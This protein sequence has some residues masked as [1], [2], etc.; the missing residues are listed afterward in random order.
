MNLK[1]I[2]T[3]IFFGAC[4]YSSAQQ[5]S[6]FANS[7]YNPY[8]LNP[9]A[10]GLMNVMQI[11]STTRFQ[12]SGY[13]GSPRTIM[14][15]G[16]APIS[17]GGSQGTDEYNAYKENF[18]GS[19]TM[20][21]GSKK[22][23]VGGKFI[24]DAIGPFMRTSLYGSYA[25]HLPFSKSINFGAG[26]GLGFSNFSINQD[27][28]TLYH[29]DD[30]TYGD[31][32]SNSANQNYL[33]ANAGIVFYSEKFMAGISMQQ[34]F[35][36]KAQF[37]DVLTQSRFNRHFFLTARYRFD[38]DFEMGIEPLT[39]IKYEIGSPISVDLGARFVYQNKFWGGLQYRT[40]NAI[41]LQAGG[42]LIKNTYLNYSFEIATGAIS[43]YSNGSHEIQLGIYIGN[44]RN[45]KKEIK[46][47]AE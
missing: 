44:N 32:L 42:N 20:S 17:I 35:N 14:L 30:L 8:L 12:W 39:V 31:F 37:A 41:I 27:R 16:N 10:G 38:T 5:E 11:E 15:T 19:P 43:T 25:I 2:Y 47:G 28:V 45:V 29:E 36:N 26:V 34:A 1:L 33:D 4:F 7:A 9:A 46:D 21:V 3:L 13:S 24:N 23:V 18:F 6:Q 22:H 40:S